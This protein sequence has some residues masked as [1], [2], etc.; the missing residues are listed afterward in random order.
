MRCE[1]ATLA[2]RIVEPVAAKL[3]ARKLEHVMGQINS[4]FDRF[5]KA[6]TAADIDFENIAVNIVEP[7]Q[8]EL[9]EAEF[10]RMVDRLKGAMVGFCQ[11]NDWGQITT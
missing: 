9:S 5:D 8:S 4:A 2:E 6:S 7:L 3:S 1:I 11:K 10:R